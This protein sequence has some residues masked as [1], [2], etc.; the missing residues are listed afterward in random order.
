MRKTDDKILSRRFIIITGIFLSVCLIVYVVSDIKDCTSFVKPTPIIK[1]TSAELININTASAEELMQ[2]D[3]IG[4]V[5]AGKIIE[6]RETYGYFISVNEL[7]EINGI[8]EGTLKRIKERL[9]V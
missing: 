1:E 7:L 9:T 2:L 5:T 6:Y 4:P 8:G 3:G